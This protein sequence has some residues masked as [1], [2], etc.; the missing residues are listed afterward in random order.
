MHA[1]DR[2]LRQ[3]GLTQHIP[4]VVDQLAPIDRVSKRR[5]DWRQELSAFIM[6]WDDRAN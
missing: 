1:P 2:V 5:Y 6:L 3:F 4:D